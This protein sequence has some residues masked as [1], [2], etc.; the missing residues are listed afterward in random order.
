MQEKKDEA[1]GLLI[2][3]G[4]CF[5]DFCFVTMGASFFLASFDRRRLSSPAV[6]C[7]DAHLFCKECA[8]GNADAQIGLRQ[9][10]RLSPVPSSQHR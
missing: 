7:P 2:E 10:V 3:C 9:Y 8:K 5:G 6:Q 1:A 4:C